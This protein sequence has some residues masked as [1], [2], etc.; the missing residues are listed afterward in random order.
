MSCTRKDCGSQD[1]N[2]IEVSM[3]L[4]F[5]I[6]LLLNVAFGA[7]FWLGW[8]R[9]AAHLRRNPEIAKLFAEHVLAVFLFGT[10]EKMEGKP[11]PK[12]VKVTLV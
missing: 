7:L 8:R 5:M 1:R 2:E 4:A 12:K 10:D 3:L 6:L 9:V 11:E